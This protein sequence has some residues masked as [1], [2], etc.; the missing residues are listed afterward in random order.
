MVQN[1]R[2]VDYSIYLNSMYQNSNVKITRGK[3]THMKKVKGV[4]SHNNWL[5][6]ST[7]T[8][9]GALQSARTSN[10]EHIITGFL[11]HGSVSLLKASTVQRGSSCFRLACR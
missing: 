11:R 8:L 6:R 3:S 7:P 5:M 2:E 10:V 9:L 1:G 4:D